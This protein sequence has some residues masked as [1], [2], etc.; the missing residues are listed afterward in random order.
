MSDV[1]MIMPL[2]LKGMDLG[3]CV[4]VKNAPVE[5]LPRQELG[6]GTSPGD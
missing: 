1:L 3:S 4:Y 6:R 5:F 2:K